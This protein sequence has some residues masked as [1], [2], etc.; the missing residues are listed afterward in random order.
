M[1]GGLIMDFENI[2]YEKKDSVLWITL[3]RPEKLNAVTVNTF[4]EL[5][6]AHEEAARD[7]DIKV[8]VS[9][10][11]GDKAFCVGGDID[12]FVNAEGDYGI[13]VCE[14]GMRLTNAMRLSPKPIIAAVNGYCYGWGNEYLIFHDIAVAT[15]NATFRQP[16]MAVGSSPVH[17]LD[18]LLPFLVGDKRA[19]EFILFRKLLTAE[20]AERIGYINRVV[21]RDKLIETVNEY[22]QLILESSPQAIKFTKT[23]MNAHSDLM[24]PVQT[25][26]FRAWTLLHGTEQWKE[27]FGAYLEKRKPDF[28]KFKSL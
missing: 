26:A 28:N 27:G 10:G 21:P 8:I 2:L 20:E 23:V 13:S 11:A 15:K 9:T 14:Y 25:L 6:V 18:Q 4:K 7:P 22:C 17:G 5:M 1:H 24:Y 16:E 19:K 3:N 12:E